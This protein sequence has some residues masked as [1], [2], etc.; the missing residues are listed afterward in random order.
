MSTKSESPER[1][2]FNP[3]S[4]R[5]GRLPTGLSA[6]FA[7]TLACSG[8][9]VDLGS[10]LGGS[11][12][13]NE[14]SPP[15][16]LTEEELRGYYVRSQAQA[17]ALEGCQTAGSL[18]V[19]LFDGL[20]LTPLRF[21]RGADDLS[22]Q[23]GYEEELA[24]A[25]RE[26]GLPVESK[27]WSGPLS[28]FDSLA[29]V[30]YFS[31]NGLPGAELTGLEGI[32]SV[33]QLTVSGCYELRTLSGLS[34]ATVSRLRLHD[35]PRLESLQG[36]EGRGP[37]LSR[38]TRVA[39]TGEQHVL[40][41]PGD[42]YVEELEIRGVPDENLDA[43]ASSSSLGELVL[44]GNP[45]LT[46]VDAL[47]NVEGLTVLHVEGNPELSHLPNFDRV[48]HVRRVSI[49]DNQRLQRLP[50]WPSTVLSPVYANGD[51]ALYPAGVSRKDG[52]LPN[53]GVFE[54][55]DNPALETVLLPDRWRMVGYVSIDRNASLRQIG[56]SGI[57]EADILSIADNPQLQSIDF[58]DLQ[59][60]DWLEI[61]N[62]PMLSE[63]ELSL[64]QVN[65]LLVGGSPLLS[66][67]PF[68]EVQAFRKN[69]GE[70]AEP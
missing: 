69:L 26:R 52:R 32:A 59:F 56:P 70:L 51:S 66:P 22:L 47:G 41:L 40:E 4:S 60:S 53:E 31:L 34:N 33:T 57:L 13:A 61:L 10:D 29:R 39:F 28:G 37:R 44:W 15:C 3:P 1:S 42:P 7:L 30:E 12:V 16:G 67:T 68:E 54:V 14:N 9:Q 5:E 55:E 27:P 18:T 43:L 21:L 24:E 58:D 45:N 63:V 25:Q 17:D 64:Q 6:V 50:T 8:R 2:V 48:E 38:V 11:D 19:H 36:P 46:Q 62:N 35:N 65:N 20:D 49:L 23:A